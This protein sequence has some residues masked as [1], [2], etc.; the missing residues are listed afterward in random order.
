VPSLDGTLSRCETHILAVLDTKEY[1]MQI[2]HDVWQVEG[3][4]ASNVFVVAAEYGVVLIDTGVPRSD[5]TILRFLAQLGYRPHDVRAIVLTHTHIDHIGSLPA[6]QQATGAV[7]CTSQG[8]ADII[9]GKRPLPQPSG[10]TWLPFAVLNVLLRPQPVPVQ[11]R[12]RIGAALPYLTGWRV[13]PTPG[14]TPDH[15]SLYH[16]AQELLIAGDAVAN[17]GGLRRSPRIFTSNMAQA[18]R[19]VALLAGLKL[20]SA[21]FGHGDPVLDDPRLPEQL[22]T[23]AR[24]DRE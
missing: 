15:I 12:L 9:E 8:E 18:Q 5:R 20:R 19:S 24:A 1:L 13:V 14:H 22:A 10:P 16:P 2:S 11:H 23:L 4:R 21:A 17:M 7:V 3:L 6:L